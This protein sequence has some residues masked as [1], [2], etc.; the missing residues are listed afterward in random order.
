[1]VARGEADGGMG[2]KEKGDKVY[3]TYDDHWVMYRIVQSLYCALETNI[4]LY[5]NNT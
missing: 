1:M 5:I 4:S 2:E 3:I